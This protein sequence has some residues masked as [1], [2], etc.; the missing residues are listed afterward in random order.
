MQIQYWFELFGTAV[1]AISGALS[2]TE[3]FNSDWFGA[4]FIG[5]IT[6]I[7]GGSLRDVLLGS[8]PVAWMRDVNLIYVIIGA[9]VVTRM[10]Y[11]S[12]VRMKKMFFLFDTMGIALFTVV[13]TTKALSLGVGYINAAMMG[14]FTA[15]FGGVIRDMLINE[16]PVIFHKEIYATACLA[17]AALYLT[18]TYFGVDVGWNQIFSGGLIFLI[19]ILAVKFDWHLPRFIK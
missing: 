2:A 18:L 5:F 6:A 12:I 11:S 13:G 3:K 10:F 9:I 16:I 15:V 17:G 14:M 7:G 8:Y 1:F 19:R 4:I